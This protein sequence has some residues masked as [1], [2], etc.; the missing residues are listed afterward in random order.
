[1]DAAKGVLLWTATPDS[2]L[3][4]E[5]TKLKGD[6]KGLVQKYFVQQHHDSLVDF[7]NSKLASN[8][9][10]GLCVQVS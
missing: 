3:R 4:L 1:M 7:L 9:R 5:K 10:N 8:E 2:V 6:S